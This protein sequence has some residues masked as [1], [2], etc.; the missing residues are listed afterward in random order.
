MSD[1]QR[2]AYAVCLDSA[3]DLVG[4]V[5]FV[6]GNLQG[7]GGA[8]IENLQALLGVRHDLFERDGIL[9]QVSIQGRLIYK[10]PQNPSLMLLF[11]KARQKVFEGDD[12]FENRKEAPAGHIPL[13]ALDVHFDCLHREVRQIVVESAVILQIP[14][15]LAFLYPE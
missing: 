5:L 10:R 14:L 9:E 2:V 12:L 11:R 1:I 8:R 6:A 3:D 15:G 7:D 13:T 4:L